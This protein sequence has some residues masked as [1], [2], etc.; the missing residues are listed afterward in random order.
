M[1]ACSKIWRII[2]NCKLLWI[3]STVLKNYHININDRFK[4]TMKNCIDFK[5]PQFEIIKNCL[6]SKIML[7]VQTSLAQDILVLCH[8]MDKLRLASLNGGPE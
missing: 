4:S 1:Y 8:L 7:I 5:V 2:I 6:Q 3:V